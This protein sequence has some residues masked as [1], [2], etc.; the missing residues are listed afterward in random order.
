MKASICADFETCDDRLLHGGVPT[1]VRVWAWAACDVDDLTTWYGDDISSFVDFMSDHKFVYYFHNLAFDGTH[2]LDY[3]L[4]NGWRYVEEKDDLEDHTFT[5]LISKSG[6][7][8]SINIKF[9][10][11][12]VE[13]RDS[14][15][16]LPFSVKTLAQTFNLPEEK[17]RIDYTRWRAP[18]YRMSAEERDYIRRDV[19]I[20]AQSLK[21]QLKEGYTKLT[22]G[23]DCMSF[24]KDTVG[25]NFKRWFP[26]INPIQDAQIRESYRGGYV[27]VN[28]TYKGIDVYDGISVDYNS[29]YSSQ[30]LL[31]PFPCGK[32][33]YFAGQYIKDKSHPL[34]VQ[35]LT[36]DFKLKP[37]YFPT[38]QLKKSGFW[39]QHEYAES[40]HG[41]VSLTLTSVDL[42][43]LF[44]NYDVDVI[45]WGGGYAFAERRGMFEEYISYW[46]AIKEVATGGL[47]QLAKLFLR[48]STTST[49]N[50]APILIAPAST[51]SLSTGY[52][53]S[54]R[55]SARR[56][57]R[58]TSRS[59]ASPRRT[60]AT[61]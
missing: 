17:G 34:Y 18:G 40:S 1:K 3:L 23:S 9:P 14:Y 7:F 41:P 54:R 22:I 21:T 43:L 46:R 51:P 58:Y 8:Y 5:S 20:V 52:S 11:H 15:K 36:C 12:T 38:I 2:I 59:R 45:S 4:R 19:Q 37:G 13:I 55:A 24:Y 57:A 50:L 25:K 47:R 53:T 39:G 35:N 27:R 31:K 33:K 61:S 42:D 49:G 30:M 28:P 56:A 32:P 26:E 10:K 60:P 48:C 44:L 16:K 29:M 6:K